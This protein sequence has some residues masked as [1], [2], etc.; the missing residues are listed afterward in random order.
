M[1]AVCAPYDISLL[2]ITQ[3]VSVA[4][5]FLKLV[6]KTDK[7]TKTSRSKT[8]DP[9]T[10]AKNKIIDALKVQKGYAQQLIHGET[11]RRR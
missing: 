1:A 11:P 5:S 8:V 4:L 6:K 9:L 3:E 10:L 2:H 7:L